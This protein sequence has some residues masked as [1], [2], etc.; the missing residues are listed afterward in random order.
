LR[1]LTKF[2]LK[3]VLKKNSF[4]DNDFDQLYEQKITNLR[5]N[6][7][8][9]C[10][11][12]CDYCYIP[13]LNKNTTQNKMETETSKKAISEFINL[14]ID[15]TCELYI[16]FFGGEPLL[17]WSVIKESVIYCNSIKNKLKIN[18]LLNTN[19]SLLREDITTFLKSNNFYIILSL[20]GIKEI[21]DM[22][23]HFINLKPSF[24]GILKSI[25]SLA[26]ANIDFGISTVVGKYNQDHLINLINFIKNKNIKSIGLNPILYGSSNFYSDPE[27]LAKKIF[28]AYKYGTEIGIS[29]GGMWKWL[30]KGLYKSSST[31]CAGIGSEISIMPN[32]DIY[33]CNGL[34]TKIGHINQFNELVNS[35]S[36]LAISKRKK[37]TIKN[38]KNC[39]IEGVC[40]GGCAANALFIN[41]DINKPAILECQF[42]K[43]IINLYLNDLKEN[44]K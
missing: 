15:K 12:S 17:N 34:E 1:A 3:F 14:N 33:P 26:E 43:E 24:S 10:N 16:R 5:L 8:I 44:L 40:N 19:G 39:F 6:V 29:V 22:H 2:D 13:L 11:F 42:Y 18:F 32:G 23:R 9:D 7:N 31:F 35:P 21:N 4:T 30:I 28:E 27:I 38:C 36:F 20:D 37:G 25:K 41:H